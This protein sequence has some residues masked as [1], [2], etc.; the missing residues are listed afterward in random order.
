VVARQ[1]LAK[2]A[3]APMALGLSVFLQLPKESK[4]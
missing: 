3:L 4:G 2:L 1:L